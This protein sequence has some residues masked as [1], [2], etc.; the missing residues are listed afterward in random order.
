[1]SSETYANIVKQGLVSISADLLHTFV[2]QNTIIPNPI[3]PE[4][5]PVVST[6]DSDIE[7][8]NILQSKPKNADLSKDPVILAND[9]EREM[10]L[11]NEQDLVFATANNPSL[12]ASE[13][14]RMYKNIVDKS[15]L[16]GSEYKKKLLERKY[17]GDPSKQGL[18]QPCPSNMHIGPY[19]FKE[20]TYIYIYG[21]ETEKNIKDNCNE[22]L[23]EQINDSEI[24]KGMINRANG[25][26]WTNGI[27]LY[28]KNS[29]ILREPDNNFGQP[30][31]LSI[32]SYYD[33]LS[34][35]IMS[36]YI[37]PNLIKQ[38][39]QNIINSKD[40]YDIARKL[41]LDT[42]GKVY[43]EKINI[44]N[45]PNIDHLNKYTLFSDAPKVETLK[46]SVR[47]SVISSVSGAEIQKLTQI[48]EAKDTMIDILDK[49]VKALEVML[50]T[51][52]NK[53]NEIEDIVL[54]LSIKTNTQ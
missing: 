33:N 41:I 43:L 49:R 22:S 3:Q 4:I 8:I 25:N 11:R 16:A 37:I 34:I 19:M 18:F 29:I 23:F 17:P 15:Y 13:K 20:D 48:I 51:T 46:S 26:K 1:M 47:D 38:I 12:P 21:E 32:V 2:Q 30:G 44:L 42:Y 7:Q 27:I 35:E 53:I 28:N 31:F 6:T 45:Q 10:A 39:N 5:T 14:L 40:G 9:Y 24:T 50:Q 54:D 52:I 36:Q